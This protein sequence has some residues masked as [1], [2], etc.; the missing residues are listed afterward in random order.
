MKSFY[1][2]LLALFL[3]FSN[4]NAATVPSND[5]KSH[6]VSRAELGEAMMMFGYNPP[7]VNPD[8]CK[9]FRITYPT[10]PGLAFQANSVQQLSWE[11]ESDLPNPP[12]IITRIRILNSTQHNQ[13][14]LG[15]NVSLY[16]EGSNGN[17]VSFPLGIQ[18]ITGLYHY[19]IMVNHPGESVHCVYESI[20]FYILQDP[21]KKYSAP[22]GLAPNPYTESNIIASA[23]E[24]CY[25][26]T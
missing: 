19:R 18:D 3:I 4:T 20:P 10:Y 24:V 9:G 16:S 5:I 8:Y 2:S 22:S 13:F 12:D 17:Q 14:I 23:N 1:T 26:Q 15:E 25:K 21:F 7:R 11:V 6:H